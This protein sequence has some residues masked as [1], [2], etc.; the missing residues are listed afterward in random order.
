M[1]KVIERKNGWILELFVINSG[2]YLLGSNSFC[3]EIRD[4]GYIP[5]T[6]NASN[7]PEAK[8]K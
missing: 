1:M 5:S 7:N 4:K 8:S 3:R 2:K 6:T